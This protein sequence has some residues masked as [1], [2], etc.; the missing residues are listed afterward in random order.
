M[1]SPHAIARHFL[2]SRYHYWYARSKLATDPVYAGVGAVLEGSHAPLLDLGC[3]L[4]LLAHTLRARGFTPDYAGVDVDA[5]KVVAARAAAEAGALTGVRFD[6]LDLARGFPDHFGSV[7]L[8]DV[9]QFVPPPVQVRILDDAA[10]RL[11]PD[12]LLVIRSGLE[13]DG[14]RLRVTR[15]VDR[16]SEWLGWMHGDPPRYPRR[17]ELEAQFERLGLEARFESLRGRT[18]FE[19]WL[20]TVRRS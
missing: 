16:W 18:P 7:C 20:I 8:L 6:T 11:A 4:G 10:A 17:V 13:R 2:P 5:R 19:N 9:L 14:W 1:T 15:A 12:A 3:G